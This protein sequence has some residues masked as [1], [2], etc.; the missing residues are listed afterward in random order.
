MKEVTV[1]GNKWVRV[2][3]AKQEIQHPTNTEFAASD[4]KFQKACQDKDLKPTSRQA[5]KFRRKLGKAYKGVQ[6]V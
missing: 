2:Q 5:S 4:V 3:A 6:Y 1:G